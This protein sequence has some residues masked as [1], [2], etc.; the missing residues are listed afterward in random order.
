MMAS[1]QNQA[2]KGASNKAFDVEEI[3]SQYGLTPLSQIQPRGDSY[4][5]AQLVVENLQKLVK[6]YEWET[7]GQLMDV[8][9][10]I[11][12]QMRRAQ[13]SESVASNMV[14]R[15]LKC[16]RDEYMTAKKKGSSDESEIKMV[17]EKK[18]D[19]NFATKFPELKDGIEDSLN[20]LLSELET[21]AESI[22]AQSFDH[23]YSDEVIM[24][25]GSDDSTVERF[26]KYAAQK[27]KFQVV[28]TES[29]PSFNGHR[30]AARLSKSGIATT[31][32]PDSS[33]FALMSRV[34]KVIIGTHEVMANGGLK[35]VS[36]TYTIALAAKHYSVPLIVCTPLYKL[37]PNYLVSEDKFN[38]LSSPWQLYPLIRDETI[39]R[40][41]LNPLFDFVPSNLVTIF[42]SNTGF[43]PSYVYQLLDELYHSNDYFD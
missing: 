16:I 19:E 10:E 30:L 18:E 23:I 11:G 27:R 5:T 40:K 31:L 42:V 43:P 26:L 21:S 37:T 1:A 12:K 38:V 36:G 15:V 22:A 20:E 13:P 28:I 24:T 7:A 17:S 2:I 8:I 9:R 41:V 32:I 35:A 29:A 33:V 6:E 39:N 14:L 34:N 25:V 4:D 3:M